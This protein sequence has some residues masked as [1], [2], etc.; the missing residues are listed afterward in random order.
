MPTPPAA[1][2][3]I[4]LQEILRLPLPTLRIRTDA[5]VEVWKSTRGYRDYALFVRMLNE[6][7]VGVSLPWDADGK[8]Y[9]EVCMFFLSCFIFILSRRICY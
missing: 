3:Q 7:V 1:P 5:D 4:P 2:L 8:G 9:C 6:S